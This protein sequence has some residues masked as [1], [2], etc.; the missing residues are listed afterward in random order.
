MYQDYLIKPQ[1]ELYFRNIKD[2]GLGVF[3]IDS[4]VRANLTTAFLQT[5]GHPDFQVNLFHKAPFDFY[6]LGI[7]VK[8]PK[9]PPYYNDDFFSSIKDAHKEGIKVFYLRVKDW[10]QRFLKRVTH[11]QEDEVSIIIASRSEFLYPQINHDNSNRCIRLSGLSSQQMSSLFKLKNY[12]FRSME[13]LEKCGKMSSPQCN[14]CYRRD[15]HAHFLMCD[16]LSLS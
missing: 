11:S 10:Y 14:L 15:E 6:I 12:L 7:G 2:G 5:T 9:K 8:A 13:R 3:H 4:K 16:G 1:E